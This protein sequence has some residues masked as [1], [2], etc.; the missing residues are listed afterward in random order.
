MKG[1]RRRASRGE[2]LAGV[3]VFGLLLLLFVGGAC[4][5]LSR[6]CVGIDSIPIDEAMTENFK[7]CTTSSS[8][9]KNCLANNRFFSPE[10]L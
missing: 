2:R 9:K 10:E 7:L 4:G 8:P 6:V 3:L 5:E 1:R